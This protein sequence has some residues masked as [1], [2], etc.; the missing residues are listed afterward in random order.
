MINV[1]SQAFMTGNW[2]MSQLQ[3]L[4]PEIVPRLS[5]NALI[6]HWTQP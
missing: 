4:N 1:N 2:W 6:A 3:E 5:W